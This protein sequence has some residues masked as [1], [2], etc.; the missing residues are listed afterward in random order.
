MPDTRKNHLNQPRVNGRFVK[1]NTTSTKKA[2]TKKGKQTKK[3]TVVTAGTRIPVTQAVLQGKTG[4]PKVVQKLINHIAFVIDRS[5]SMQHLRQNVVDAFNE[6]VKTIKQNAVA[7]DQETYVH[8]YDFNGSVNALQRGAFHET[9]KFMTLSD[10][11]PAGGTALVDAIGTAI[12]DLKKVKDADD[13]NTSF[14]VFVITDGE[15]NSSHRYNGRLASMISE[16][17]KTDR[18]SLVGLVPPGGRQ[19]LAL[20]GVPL[21]NVQ[22][23]EATKQGVQTFSKNLSVGTQAYYQNR[24]LGATKSVNFFTDASKITSK[25]LQKLNQVNSLFTKW[26]VDKE[27]RIDDFVNGKL[28]AGAYRPGTTFYKLTKKEKIQGHKELVIRNRKSGDIFSGVQVRLLLGLPT[29]G[30]ITVHPGNHGEYDIFVES[31][32]M[33]RKLVRGTEVL[34]R[35]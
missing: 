35:G 32:S 9:V 5:G 29:G 15:E 8:V 13:K 24:S 20:Y 34:Y 7:A 30:E 19:A 12:D 21:G 17:Q 28:K 25:D 27:A 14:L 6:Q 23:W 33:N 16:V 11:Y 26:Q 18:W 22:E 10:Y 31:T 1:K 3:D 2:A 4:Q